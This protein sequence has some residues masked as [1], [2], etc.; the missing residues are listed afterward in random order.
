MTVINYQVIINIQSYLAENPQSESR[1][2]FFFYVSVFEI[3]TKINALCDKIPQEIQI[4]GEDSSGFKLI[5]NAA[6]TAI[7]H[8]DFFWLFVS[9]NQNFNN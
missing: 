9:K 6:N 2:T 4:R 3:I 1:L 7:I 5:T 8:Y